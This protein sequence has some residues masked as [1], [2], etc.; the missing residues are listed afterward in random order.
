M[1]TVGPD[2]RGHYA[3][4]RCDTRGRMDNT[5]D[6]QAGSQIMFKIVSGHL[7]SLGVDGA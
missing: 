7:T 2:T 4:D 5:F 6:S 3:G 1:A